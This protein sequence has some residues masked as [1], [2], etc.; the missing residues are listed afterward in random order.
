MKNYIVVKIILVNELKLVC[1]STQVEQ[2]FCELVRQKIIVLNTW[3]TKQVPG[4][5]STVHIWLLFC[6]IEHWGQRETES[7][8]WG[9]ERNK[10]FV[11][12]KLACL[13][14]LTEVR[15]ERRA[16]TILAHVYPAICIKCTCLINASCAVLRA[17]TRDREWG[18]LRSHRWRERTGGTSMI[19]NYVTRWHSRIV[20]DRPLSAQ[21]RHPDTPRLDSSNLLQFHQLSGLVERLPRSKTTI[22]NDFIS[23]V[24]YVTIIV[25][26]I[27]F[28][29]QYVS[30][31][32]LTLRKSFFFL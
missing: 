28:T 31:C 4:T 21:S 23:I 5:S 29:L 3:N 24:I 30:P 1:R 8:R 18:M 27:F 15:N 17:H 22:I 6:W 12:R 11:N 14:P 26:Q 13:I 9:H 19:V 25:T 10:T 16:H 2:L 20:S 7:S 32:E